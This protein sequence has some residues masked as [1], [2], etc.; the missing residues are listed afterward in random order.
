MFPHV[1]ALGGVALCSGL[2]DRAPDFTGALPTHTHMHTHTHVT[3]AHSRAHTR[4]PHSGEV[5]SAVGST[6]KAMRDQ[7]A[8]GS[9]THAG[10]PP[11]TSYD[12]Y[13]AGPGGLAVW[14]WVVGTGREWLCRGGPCEV[15]PRRGKEVAGSLLVGT[16]RSVRPGPGAV[17]WGSLQLRDRL[18]HFSGAS[19]PTPH[20]RL[21]HTVQKSSGPRGEF[22]LPLSL[23]LHPSPD[24]GLRHQAAATVSESSREHGAAGPG[25]RLPGS[26]LPPTPTD[27]RCRRLRTRL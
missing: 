22:L 8:W 17:R 9:G 7:P 21:A 20:R 23:R 13:R 2:S 14:Q 27:S 3:C 26:L 1:S 15:P 18:C 25:D 16:H 10:L 5:V 11:A 6:E 19:E 24:R 12:G 4:T